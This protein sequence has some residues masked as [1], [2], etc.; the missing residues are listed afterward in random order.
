MEQVSRQT[1]IE[2]TRRFRYAAGYV[3]EQEGSGVV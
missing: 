2:R 3:I 1:K